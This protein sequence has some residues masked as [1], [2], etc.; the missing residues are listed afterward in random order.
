MIVM[1]QGWS[2]PG[3]HV[4]WRRQAICL[5]TGETVTIGP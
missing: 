5:A 1:G 2:S 4:A 3:D